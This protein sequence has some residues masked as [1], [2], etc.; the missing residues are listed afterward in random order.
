V[1]FFG[2]HLV[3]SRRLGIDGKI[4]E[5]AIPRENGNRRLADFVTDDGDL[6]RRSRRCPHIAS[7]GERIFIDELQVFLETGLGPQPPLASGVTHYG[8]TA[9][10]TLNLPGGVAAGTYDVIVAEYDSLAVCWDLS[11]QG[12]KTIGAARILQI[13]IPALRF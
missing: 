10:G 6:I 3:G 2:K 5:M 12:T 4:Y 13:G 11:D 9:I 1:E 8:A 7:E